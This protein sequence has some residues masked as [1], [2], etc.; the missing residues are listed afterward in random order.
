MYGFAVGWTFVYA[1]QRAGNPPTRA[2]LMKAMHSLNTSQNPFVY[3]GIKLQTSAKDNFPIE[4]EIMIKW[5]GGKTGD[6]HPFGK[7]LS[8]VR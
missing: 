3:P 8:G 7:L 6:W 1:L 4:Q 5:S 2:G